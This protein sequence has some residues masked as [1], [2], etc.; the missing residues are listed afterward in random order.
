M[1]D[2]LPGTLMPSGSTAT[3]SPTCTALS[4]P[5]G[6]RPA[7]PCSGAVGPATPPETLP[8]ALFEILRRDAAPHTGYS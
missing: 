4:V 6:N 5:S 2:C 3:K 7:P 8:D 1:M